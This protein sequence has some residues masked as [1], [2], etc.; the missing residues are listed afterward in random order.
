MNISWYQTAT[1][2]VEKEDTKILFDPF[3]TITP[4]RNIYRSEFL[5]TFQ[6]VDAI[7]I[8]H[9][10]FDH[11][12]DVPEIIKD[13]DIPVYCT[14]APLK[15]LQKR[16]GS[17]ANLKCIA[18]GDSFCIG[19]IE[20]TAYKGTHASFGLPLILKTVFRK[21]FWAMLPAVMRIGFNAMFIEREAKQILVFE[22][23]DGEKSILI[24]GSMGLF[25]EEKYPQNVDLLA[26]PYQGRSDL[27]E[28]SMKVI[29]TVHPKKVLLTHFN[30]YCPPISSKVDYTPFL[31]KM[32]SSNDPI[33]VLVMPLAE[34][35]EV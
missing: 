20:I 1:L 15:M 3:F 34:K 35:L 8:T 5:E 25:K 24:L 30:D 26:L 28:Y 19:D 27:A 12:R 31:D 32:K 33:E 22:V 23:K 4:Q 16:V 10:H 9:G 7:V 21:Q 11:I 29:E 14:G 2:I 13:K 18:P 6:S 17:K